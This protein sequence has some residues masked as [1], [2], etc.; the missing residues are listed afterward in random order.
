MRTLKIAECQRVSG[1]VGVE[2]VV[3][4]VGVRVRMLVESREGV[5]EVRW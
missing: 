1:I 3:L 4:F 2:L 5:L